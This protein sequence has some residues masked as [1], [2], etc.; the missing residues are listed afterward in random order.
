M[1]N[2]I[3]NLPKVPKEEPIKSENLSNEEKIAILNY[4]KKFMS[5]LQSKIVDLENDI[6]INECE[7]QHNSNSNSDSQPSIN[8]L[9]EIQPSSSSGSF[10]QPVS[11][12]TRTSNLNVSS[13]SDEDFSTD[14]ALLKSLQPDAGSS[15]NIRFTGNDHAVIE[16]T[17]NL[18]I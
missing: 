9:S 3:T 11:S 17:D 10:N 15:Q 13:S 7:S 1:Y 18:Q 12:T 8:L 4:S 16:V 6:S 2:D 14:T 5:Q